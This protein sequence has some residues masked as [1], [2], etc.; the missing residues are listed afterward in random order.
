MRPLWV[1]VLLGLGAVT[2]EAADFE[3]ASVTPP[4]ALTL[5]PGATAAVPVAISVK[6]GYHVQA[7]PVL[8]KFLIPVVLDLKPAAGVAPGAPVYPPA[9]WMRLHGSDEDLVVYDGKFTIAQPVTAGAGNSAGDAQLQGILRY[10]ACD[11]THC[12]RP[13]TVPVQLTVHIRR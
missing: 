1:G 12:L 8:N 11:A 7:N 10:Q 5:K 2:A 3:A 13:R 4:A 6:P 9:R